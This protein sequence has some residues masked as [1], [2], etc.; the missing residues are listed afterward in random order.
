M[1]KSPYRW[2]LLLVAL[3]VAFTL[4]LHYMV[5][6]FPHWIHLLHRRLCYFP[7][8]L[9]GLWFGLRG[10]LAVSALISAA[11]IPLVLRFSGPLPENQDFL[12]ILFYLGIGVLTGLLVDRREMERTHREAMQSQ[13]AESE[14]L[15]AIGRMAGGGGP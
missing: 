4:S 5:L 1:E 15:A 10:G 2:K 8:V 6:P 14:R 11:T 7:I 3:L 9:G 13:L 12:E